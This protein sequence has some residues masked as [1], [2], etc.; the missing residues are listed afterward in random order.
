MEPFFL[1]MV[2]DFRYDGGGDALGHQSS[3]RGFEQLLAKY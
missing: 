3:C 1:K 2:H